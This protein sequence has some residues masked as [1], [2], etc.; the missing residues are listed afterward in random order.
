MSGLRYLC[1][2]GNLIVRPRR[3]VVAAGGAVTSHSAGFSY[4][5]AR[6]LQR[7][8]SDIFKVCLRASSQVFAQSSPV[9]LSER[10]RPPL[11]LSWCVRLTQVRQIQSLQCCTVLRDSVLHTCYSASSLSTCCSAC[12]MHLCSVCPLRCLQHDYLLLCL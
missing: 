10:Q 9:S 6:L 4:R 1:L 12:N 3:D 11:H 8:V 7:P 2:A 5:Y